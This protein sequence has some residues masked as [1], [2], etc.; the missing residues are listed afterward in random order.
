MRRST[1]L[2]LRTDT[3]SHL[4]TFAEAAERGSFTATARILGITQAAVSQRVQALER[5]LGVPLFRRSGD[6]PRLREGAG[7]RRFLPR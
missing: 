7:A 6:A 2:E 5:E 4:E 1:G 3:L